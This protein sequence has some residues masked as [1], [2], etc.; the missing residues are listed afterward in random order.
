ML[1]AL[2]VSNYLSFKDEISL[3]LRGT[4][5]RRHASRV[6]GH[7][8]GDV[9]LLPV[10]ALFG[11]NG[12]GK[13]NLYRA[14]R[15]LQRLVLRSPGSPD[16]RITVDNFRLGDPANDGEPARFVVEFLPQEVAY[17]FSLSIDGEGVREEC[18]EEIRG[19]RI[20]LLYSRRRGLSD[21]FQWN[22]DQLQRR[23]DAVQDR[24]FI[25]F[26]TRD[27]WNNQLFLTALRGKQLAAIDEV[28]SWFTEQLV[29]MV[30][31][32]TLKL[33]ESNISAT[34]GL[35]QFCNDV[36]RA[37]STGIH[38]LQP[39]EVPW[40]SV[41]VSEETKDEV[42]KRLTEGKSLFV[43]SA[44]G[45]RFSVARRNGQL[46]VARLFTA[47]RA[48]SGRLVRFELGAESEGVQRLLDLLPAFFELVQPGRRRVFFID[49][50]DRSLHSLLAVQLLKSYLARL[51]PGARRQLIFTTYDVTL[52]DQE[53]LRRDE[54]CFVQRNAA[55]ES[56]LL[57][58]ANVP[59]VRYD[60]DIRKAYLSGLFG[61]VPVFNDLL[62][63]QLADASRRPVE[64]P[65][66]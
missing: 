41:S 44:D 58:L 55:G 22:V 9:K 4:R 40:S 39:E 28:I 6:F 35:L 51:E 11:Q 32:S 33:L 63:P 26:K 56:V 49:E 7:G 61:A 17:R 10:I 57:P 12:S 27:T 24:R 65:P 16:E 42:Q 19:E 25:E 3:S 13:T 66:A 54:I 64:L 47:H 53:I 60:K 20:Q 2:H 31:D 36:I 29:L 52:L 15:F 46:V 43:R 30:P 62:F 23:C 21:Q 8:R 14:V 34:E 48:S 45:R 38:E 18:L 37:S 5:E 1:I 50:L 59:G